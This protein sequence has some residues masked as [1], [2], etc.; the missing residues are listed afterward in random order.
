MLPASSE[1]AGPLRRLYDWILKWADTQYAV[2]ALIILAVTEAFFFP[3]PVETLLIPMAL[4]ARRKALRYAALCTLSSVLGG[5]I[6]YA[7][8]RWLFVP[9][10]EPWLRFISGLPLLS[11]LDIMGKFEALKAAFSQRSSLYIFIAALTP[12]PYMICTN[13]TGV[14]HA[15]VRFELF[16]L[17]SIVGRG[18]RF[19]SIGLLFRLF[20]QRIRPFVER[21][22]NLLTVVFVVLLVLAF[23]CVKIVFGKG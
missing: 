17:A 14:C 3:I 7:V 6:G 13:A 23:I 8:G 1:R 9:V 16:V 11:W 4:A 12:A 15:N 21:Y 18:L 22:F 10:G 19:F 2:W 5:C 20:G